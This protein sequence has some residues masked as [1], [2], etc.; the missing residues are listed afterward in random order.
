M[1]KAIFCPTCKTTVLAENENF[2]FCSDRCRLLD[3][4]AWASGDYKIS[5]PILDPEL[6]EEV[7]QSQLLAEARNNEDRWKH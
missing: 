7:E 5:S 1:T 4:G 2:P 3:L 6:L